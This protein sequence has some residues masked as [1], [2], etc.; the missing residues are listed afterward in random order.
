VTNDL[1]KKDYWD[2]RQKNS[3]FKS[4]MQCA[5]E[6]EW[7]EKVS[8]KIDLSK[9]Y[10]T[11]EIGCNPGYATLA[12]YNYINGVAN[13]VDFNEHDQSFINNLE[14][15]KIKIGDLYRCDVRDLKGAS[16]YDFVFSCGFIEHFKNYDEM[17]KIHSDLLDNDGLLVIAVPN[18]RYLQYLYHWIFDREDL[19]MHNIEV[20][21]PIILAEI[22]SEA[23]MKVIEFGYAGKLRFWNYST[24][25]GA[26]ARLGKRIFSKLVRVTAVLVSK[27]LPFES[28]YYSP[29][30]YIIASKK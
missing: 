12:I 8:K 23:K 10:N 29:W 19:R 5:S 30:I 25:G 2:E 16:K 13:G 7:A 4:L 9:N 6:N 17:I 28:K 26:V 11:L 15:N 24:S 18:F 1:T 3:Q 20:M 22:L 14:S 27:F 21:D